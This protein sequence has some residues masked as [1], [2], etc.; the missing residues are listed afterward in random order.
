MELLRGAPIYAAGE[1]GELTTPTGAALLTAIAEGFGARP[2]MIVERIGYGAGSKDFP[3]AANVLRIS[4]GQAMP[5][6]ATHEST[7]GQ[8]VVIEANVDDMNPQLYGHFQEKA[9]AAGALDI[10]LTS[11]QMKK[12]R[13]GT[14][15]TLIC[16]PDRLDVLA[17]ILFSETTTIGIRYSY[18][19][20]KTLDREFVEVPTEFGNVTVKV[21]SSDGRRLNFA[22]EY[23][24][25]RRLAEQSG[26]PLKDIMASAMCAYLDRRHS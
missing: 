2:P 17:Q 20:R 7:A 18:A 24:C 5:A 15:L 13:P 11:V 3:H 23:E 19:A 26:A 21:C 12:N 9:L 16:D 22:P 6:H 14:L 4:L 1:T 10:F 8:V 25:C